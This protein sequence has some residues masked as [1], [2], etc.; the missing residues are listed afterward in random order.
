VEQATTDAAAQAQVFIVAAVKLYREGLALALRQADG[1]QIAG[2]AAGPLEFGDCLATVPRPVLLLDVGTVTGPASLAQVLDAYPGVRVLALGLSGATA[3]IVEWIESGASGYLT[4][5]H[6]VAD[7][8]DA[9][10][11]VV[12]DELSCP[13]PVAGA[14]MRRVAVLASERRRD[15]ASDL[16]SRREVEIVML[17]DRGLSNKQIAAQL[18]ITVATVKNH[19]HNILEKLKVSARGDA[20]AYL[21]ALHSRAPH[22]P[23]ANTVQPTGPAR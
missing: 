10:R 22:L 19:V 11:S 17:I 12:H 15:W 9:I 3:E 5:Q 20:A 18:F 21:R 2:V 1:V 13:P 8:A 23:H 16:L 6:S 14:L 4:R 7:L